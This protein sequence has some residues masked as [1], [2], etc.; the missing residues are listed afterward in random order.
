MK[1]LVCVKLVPDLT[2]DVHPDETGMGYD[3]AG[4]AA[5]MNLY[6]E[7]AV[8]EAL[9]IREAGTGEPLEVVA[10]SAGPAG[11]TEV[12]R[13]A[14]SMGVDRAVWIDDAHALQGDA[15]GIAAE[16]AAHVRQEGYDLVLAG[17]V[18]EDMGRGEVGPM[19]AAILGWPCATSVVDLALSQD[20]RGI[21]IEREIEG[22]AREVLEVPLPTVL[23]IQTG[24][25][26]ARYPTL[27]HTL[28]ARKAP[29]ERIEPTRTGKAGATGSAG[30]VLD[31]RLP[32]STG[33]VEILEGNLEAVAEALVE[34]IHERTGVV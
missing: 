22:G 5:R 13:R 2:G 23:T 34:R 33:R 29:I 27:T 1:I 15:F 26:E 4:H 24:A 7:Q 14:M 28:R 9:L 31:V 11:A 32:S 21:R 3:P 8:E 25:R 10:L 12:L 6:D 19:I 30:T 17:V 20:G 18:S 16:I